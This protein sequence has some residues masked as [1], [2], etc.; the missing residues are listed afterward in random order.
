MMLSC[1]DKVVPLDVLS[2]ISWILI[3]GCFDVFP[4]DMSSCA[5]SFNVSK[6][7]KQDNEFHYGDDPF[8]VP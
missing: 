7:A 5:D 4:R 2:R 8:R 1:N 6:T 3:L